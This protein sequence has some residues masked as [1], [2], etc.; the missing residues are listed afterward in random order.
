MDTAVLG[1]PQNPRGERT[2]LPDQVCN[3]LQLPT[4]ACDVLYSLE[5]KSGLFWVLICC[6]L[7]HVTELLQK[8]IIRRKLWLNTT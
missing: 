5:S 6:I 2:P 4:S 3:Q 8:C 1:V 7:A